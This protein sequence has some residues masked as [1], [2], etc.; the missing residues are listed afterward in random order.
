MARM[1]SAQMGGRRVGGSKPRQGN[2]GAAS[3]P[4]APAAKPAVVKIPKRGHAQIEQASNGVTISVR[5][6]NYKETTKVVAPDVN[7]V[8]F[9]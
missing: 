2:T 4:K 1:T 5:D 8:K 6:Q 7:S 3:G 9:E